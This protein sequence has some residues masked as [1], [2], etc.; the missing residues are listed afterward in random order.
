MGEVDHNQGLKNRGHKFTISEYF[1]ESEYI[2]FREYCAA[3]NLVSLDE[4]RPY[5][6][7]AF[8]AQFNENIEFVRKI[9]S[10]VEAIKLDQTIITSGTNSPI[11]IN[12]DLEVVSPM[13]L[14]EKLEVTWEESVQATAEAY[15]NTPLDQLELPNRVRHRLMSAGIMTIGKMLLTTPEQFRS[16][17][18]IGSQSLDVIK[19]VSEDLIYKHTN[20]PLHFP[21]FPSEASQEE[22]PK[23]DASGYIVAQP[24]KQDLEHQPSENDPNGTVYELVLCAAAQDYIDFS[25]DI[26]QLP[27]RAYNCLMRAGLDSTDKVLLATDEQLLSIKTIGSLVL[28][29]ILNAKN[30]FLQDYINQNLHWQEKI[31]GLHLEIEQL[32]SATVSNTHLRLSSQLRLCIENILSGNSQWDSE[33]SFATQESMMLEKAKRSVEELGVELCQ[34][35]YK[36]PAGAQRLIQIFQTYIDCQEAS[37]ILLGLLVAIPESRRSKPLLPFIKLFSLAQNSTAVGDLLDVFSVC[38]TIDDIK[39]NIYDIAVYGNQNRIKKLLNWLSIDHSQIIKPILVEIIGE[40]RKGQI[41]SRRAHGDTLESISEAFGLTRERIRQI[42]AKA[43]REFSR[44]HITNPLLLAISV[45][46]NGETIITSDDIRRIIPESEALLY[47]LRKN[48][49]SLF[50]YDD[51]I[52]CFYLSTEIDPDSVYEFLATLPKL[53]YE[54]EQ[55]ILLNQ[56]GQSNNIPQK[57]L[58]LAFKNHY[59][60]T[61]KIWHV[62][63]MNRGQIYS[64]IIDKYFPNGIR[65]YDGDEMVRFKKHIQEDFGYT[66]LS[67]NDRALWGIIQ[68]TCVLLDRGVYIHPSRMNISNELVNKIEAYFVQS[69]RTSMA[70]H[71]LYDKFAEELLTQANITN[72][73]SLQGLL[74]DRLEDKYIF[75]KDGISTKEG[76]KITQEIETYIRKNS[77]VSKEMLKTVFSGIT[78]AMLMQN[79][80]RLPSVIL[81]DNSTYI[82]SKSLKLTAGDHSIIKILK[83]Y[84][85][86]YPVTASKLLEVLYSTH[87]D[88]LFRNNISTPN[89][90]FGILQ[91]MFM[92][93]FSFSRPYIG[94]LTMEGISKREIILSLLEGQERVNIADLASLCEE[95][96]LPFQ[97]SALLTRALKNDFLRINE[98]T[99]VSTTCIQ[100]TNEKLD[101]IK[102]LLSN[103]ILLKGYLVFKSIDNYIFYPD[104]GFTWT[105]YLLRSILDKYFPNDF[106]IIDNPTNQDIEYDLIVDPRLEID[107]F[108]DLVRSVIRTEHQRDPFKDQASVVMWLVNEGFLAKKA[109]VLKEGPDLFNSPVIRLVDRHIPKFITDKNFMY[110]D[111]YSKLIIR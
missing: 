33:I 109:A 83:T 48:P 80:A 31:K 69:G 29:Q 19:V 56:I 73:Y 27:V 70:F 23:L 58:E 110:I 67:E 61:G 107:N 28:Q 78:E 4:L 36:D 40:D 57:Y 3:N 96:H 74:R 100:V 42:E 87:S 26:L 1:P 41:L 102:D 12:L 84:T 101:E 79:I 53:I 18:F 64:F 10:L 105:P 39:N 60:Q 68:R 77:P 25:I 81:T 88:F 55:G 99:L 98:D 13:Q 65:I 59:R 52:D 16:I 8:R 49:G 14:D 34:Q 2:Q 50:K 24:D 108:E 66:G 90:L 15:M 76:F 85:N 93:E 92:D 22:A 44:H 106:K 47:L 35:I 75:Y 111:E 37:K 17:G 63:K 30:K 95:H 43:F 89:R 62:G 94:S 9:R 21:S 54:S 103:A 82:H 11:P 86:D 104:L 32:A 97:S 51:H 71:E 7:V 91:F 6:Y 72:R 5:D 20:R 46:L 45:E 38:E